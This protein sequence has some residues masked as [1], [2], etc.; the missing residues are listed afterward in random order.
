VH[1][2]VEDGLKEG[3]PIVVTGAL[4]LKGEHTRKDLGG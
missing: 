1:T 3:E 4:L 2:V